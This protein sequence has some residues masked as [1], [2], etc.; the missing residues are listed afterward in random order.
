MRTRKK[1]IF[2][3]TYSWRMRI[4]LRNRIARE[5]THG[6]DKAMPNTTRLGLSA[7]QRGY[8]Y[9]LMARFLLVRVLEET[10]ADG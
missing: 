9:S 2:D 5:M 6:V 3:R 1:Q 10:R 4:G 7:L 8:S